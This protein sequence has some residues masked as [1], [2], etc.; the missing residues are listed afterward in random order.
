MRIRNTGPKISGA[1]PHGEVGEVDDV[2][3]EAMIRR[4][5]A[6]EVDSLSAR[7][8]A[9]APGTGVE[10]EAIDVPLGEWAELEGDG[11]GEALPPPQS[12]KLLRATE[13]DDNGHALTVD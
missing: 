11:S 9:K 13:L 6:I 8:G 12:A 5:F 4:G 10:M 2:L 3:G 7:L 1:P